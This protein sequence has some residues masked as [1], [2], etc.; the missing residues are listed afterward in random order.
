MS[1]VMVWSVEAVLLG[2]WA[3]ALAAYSTPLHVFVARSHLIVSVFT[4]VLHLYV[5]ARDL[6]VGSAVSQA[7]VC[8]VSALFLGYLSVL[9]SHGIQSSPAFFSAPSVGPLTLDACVGLAWFAVAMINGTG[10]A[11][12]S[13]EKKHE[14]QGDGVGYNGSP[15][16]AFAASLGARKTRLMF[17][18]HGLHLVVLIP[19][20]AMVYA[21]NYTKSSGHGETV[22]TLFFGVIYNPLLSICWVIYIICKAA[23]IFTKTDSDPIDGFW[24][25]FSLL[26]TG[27]FLVTVPLLLVFN[28]L[29]V[30]QI[31]FASTLSFV[32]IVNFIPTLNLYFLRIPILRG[33][34]PSLPAIDAFF[35]RRE[36]DDSNGAP[37]AENTGT[38][39][40]ASAVIGGTPNNAASFS[41]PTQQQIL[42]R[43]SLSA[44]ASDPAAVPIHHRQLRDKVVSTMRVMLHPFQCSENA[45]RSIFSHVNPERIHLSRCWCAIT[46][47][48]CGLLVIETHSMGNEL[49]VGPL[50][51][52][53][54]LMEGNPRR[55][56]IRKLL[57]LTPCS[58]RT[59][60]M[61][62]MGLIHTP[63]CIFIKFFKLF[64]LYKRTK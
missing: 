20:L 25:S 9:L 37:G 10:M 17:H 31:I 7:F 45:P 52:G 12:S 56:L 39:P 41:N 18:S 14:G 48:P 33:F 64:F 21:I 35:S 3:V 6:I 27:L 16:K 44:A 59:T 8:F 50:L 47:C 36:Y 42:P 26:Y 23:L 60:L 43:F 13:V 57:R 19:C 28:A 32:S 58:G 24:S 34:L 30:P 63:T 54:I 5:R 62:I 53:K 29:S 40:P 38:A 1:S 61:V 49:S 11:F 51:S 22:F 4:M 2:L 55:F 15:E 46:T